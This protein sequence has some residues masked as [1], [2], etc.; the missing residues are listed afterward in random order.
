MVATGLPS[1]GTPWPRCLCTYLNIVIEA[2]LRWLQVKVFEGQLHHIAFWDLDIPAADV[3]VGIWLGIT[4]GSDLPKKGKTSW[5]RTGTD[6]SKKEE[7]P[8]ETRNM[9][10][11]TINKLLHCI[12]LGHSKSG[13]TSQ[14]TC[15]LSKGMQTQEA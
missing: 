14:L 13:E 6:H 15:A 7:D 8:W 2:G 11:N 1:P 9:P 4:G 10:V 12:K 5:D 3:I